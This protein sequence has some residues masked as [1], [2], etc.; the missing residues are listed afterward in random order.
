MDVPLVIRPFGSQTVMKSVY[1]AMHKFVEV[2]R[3]EVSLCACLFLSASVCVRVR[4]CLSVCF[5]PPLSCLFCFVWLCLGVGEYLAEEG[6]CSFLPTA[7]LALSVCN[8]QGDNQYH[9]EKCDK[10]V[11]ALKYLKFKAFPY[12]LTLQLKRFDFDYTTFHRIKLNSRSVRSSV[13]VC[14]CVCVSVC[15]CVCLC[16]PVCACVFAVEEH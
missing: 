8:L 2:E 10:K 7:L 5:C 15:V 4:A 1:E 16:V 11:D 12:L 9:C 13:C 3:M 14:V 6:C